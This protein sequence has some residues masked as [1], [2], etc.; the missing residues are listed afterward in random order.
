MGSDATAPV[1][2]AH[3]CHSGRADAA[4]LARVLRRI[5]D[6]VSNTEPHRLEAALLSMASAVDRMS[7]ELLLGFAHADDAELAAAVLSRVSD[8]TIARFL[9]RHVSERITSFD[10]LAL[11]VQALTPDGGRQQ[12]LLAFACE[13]VNGSATGAADGFRDA[14]DELRRHLDGPPVAPAARMPPTL[15]LADVRARALDVEEAS[16]DPPERIN[17]WLETVSTTSLGALD[18]AMVLDLLRIDDDAGRWGTL[19]TPVIRLLD[20][21]LLVGDFEAA[22]RLVEVLVNE[23]TTG[24]PERRAYAI[25]AI[26]ILIDSATV[27]H[28][29]AHLATTTDEQFEVAKAMCLSLGEVIVRPLAEALSTEE[30][31]AARARLTSILLAFGPVGRRTLDRLKSSPHPAIRRTALHLLRVGDAGPA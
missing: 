3:L 14:W 9:A 23:A 10:Q 28:I 20:D 29:T 5:V 17:A 21:L 19:M 16:D 8:D 27:R 24:R 12:R 11:A 18:L 26:D 25:D 4:V 6:H 15:D 31:P 13:D 22:Q 30:R 1:D 7:P 2:S